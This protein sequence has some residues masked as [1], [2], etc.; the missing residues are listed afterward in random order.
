MK[1]IINEPKVILH[2]LK[3]ILIVTFKYEFISLI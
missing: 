3:Y 2:K 1:I